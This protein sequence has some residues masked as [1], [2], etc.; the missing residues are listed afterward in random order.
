MSE[1]P[2]YLI[3]SL[4]HHSL[5]C[6]FSIGIGDISDN[7]PMIDGDNDVTNIITVVT[8]PIGIASNSYN[9]NVYV[10]NVN[11]STVYGIGETPPQI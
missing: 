6:I 3:C 5:F 9:G 2:S 4:R 11:S 7:A 8:G 1:T 10:T